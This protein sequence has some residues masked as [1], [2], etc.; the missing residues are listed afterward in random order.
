MTRNGG[1]KLG[2]DESMSW[3]ELKVMSCKW[4]ICLTW[5]DG[6]VM[7]DKNWSKFVRSMKL[8]EGDICVF[9]YTKHYQKF[10]VAVYEKQN[11]NNVNFS[12]YLAC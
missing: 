9:Q 10:K 12:G 7:F 3:L 4:K 2:L 1:Y 5:T 11:I 8:N 6:L